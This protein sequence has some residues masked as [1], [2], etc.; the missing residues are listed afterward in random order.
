MKTALIIINVGWAEQR[1]SPFRGGAMRGVTLIELT[2]VLLVLIALAGVTLPMFTGTPNYAQ[3]VATDATMANIR[4][5]IM[6]SGGMAGYRNDNR[7]FYE[8]M[9]L[10]SSTLTAP[11]SLNGLFI[12]TTNLPLFNP[13][14]QRGW[15]GPYISG[16]ITCAEIAGKIPTGYA[17]TVD[18][19]NV[20]QLSAPNSYTVA[21]DS[22]PAFARNTTTGNTTIILQGSPIVLIQDTNASSTTHGKY[23]L[24]SGGATGGIE[25]HPN[26]STN[27]TDMATRSNDDR[28]LYLDAPDPKGGNPSC[29]Q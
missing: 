27:P 12:N 21:L 1:C 9:P 2:V 15:R 20:C 4:D 29:S 13:T 11:S 23:F 17:Q 8:G 18:N 28:V 25:T 24:V 5:A 7:S 22:F 19:E 26:T 10:D 16:G 14:T 3:C 6:G